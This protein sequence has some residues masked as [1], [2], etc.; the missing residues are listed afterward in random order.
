[1]DKKKQF[2][3]DILNGFVNIIITDVANKYLKK[4]KKDKKNPHKL[5]ENYLDNAVC[6]TEENVKIWNVN[7]HINVME[8]ELKEEFNEIIKQDEEYELIVNELNF[9]FNLIKYEKIQI[10]VLNSLYEE[11]IKF[12]DKQKN[13]II[14]LEEEKI[15]FSSI[16]KKVNRKKIT[17]ALSY[18]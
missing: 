1:M 10:K 8:D 16:M 14:E 18:F 2:S 12:N 7:K 11:F 13:E 4:L 5:I 15:N 17:S 6:L 3:I 9:A